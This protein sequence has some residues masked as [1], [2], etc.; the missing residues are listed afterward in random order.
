MKSILTVLFFLVK[1]ACFAQDSTVELSPGMF[2][3]SQLIRLA[4][5]QGWIYKPGND[6]S[7]ANPG[8]NTGDWEKLSPAQLTKKM[9]AKDGR[10]EG[11]FRIKIKPD[12]SFAGMGNGLGLLHGSWSA[13]EVYIDGK[14]FHAFGNPGNDR[15]TFKAY[16]DN[17]KM[18]VPVNLEAGKDH[19]LA[20]HFAD[21]VDPVLRDLR[22]AGNLTAFLSLAAPGYTQQQY[23]DAIINRQIFATLLAMV[24]VLT[25][26]FW[27]IYFQNRKEK[28]LLWIAITA[29]FQFGLSLSI[30]L[31]NAENL[32]YGQ[33]LVNQFIGMISVQGFFVMIPITIR[34]IFRKPVPK[35]YWLVAGLLFPVSILF[36]VLGT[37][38]ILVASIIFVSF[39][40]CAVTIIS[41]WKSLSGARWAIVTGL[42]ASVSIFLLIIISN[43]L[44]FDIRGPLL[45]S[46][47]FISFPLGLLVYVSIWFKESR[48]AVEANAQK[49]IRVTEEKKDLL[50]NQNRLLEQQ[51]D[52]RTAE[53]KRSLENL[54]A[55]QSQL[56]QSEKM[57][58]LGELTAGIAH[59][60][61]N[62]L[63]FVNNFSEVSN[64]L[65][66]EMNVEIEKGDIAEAKTIGNDIKQ[67]LEKILH[68][69][70]RADAIVKGMLQHS[71]SSSGQKE[72]TDINALCDEYLRL[73][74]HGLRAKDKNFNA[75]LETDFDASLAKVNVVPQDI[76]R[77]V[78]NLITNAFYA[79]HEKE[80]QNIAGYEPTVTVSTRNENGKVIIS[81]KD[82]GNGIPDSIKDKIF[83]P[84]FTTK[85]TGQGTGLGLSLSYDIIKA[86]SG[87]IKLISKEEKGTEFIIQLPA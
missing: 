84:F 45:F 72:P 14:L 31:S 50:A 73:A 30:L 41:S 83:Q 86:H 57:A 34:K 26:L 23:S 64:E 7:W 82:N 12:S 38:K 65:I 28:H 24:S 9:A 66:D 78:L 21:Y 29:T 48:V 46:L 10:L 60:I 54:K 27:L 1:L 81:V 44:G 55:T 16:N 33:S 70:K 69:G 4:D 53:L 6:T 47:L 62:P 19:L 77:V 11:W 52:E 20:I 3:K 80:K 15:H 87:E 67:N 59:E 13:A 40:V 5:S 51:V 36:R 68:H 43:M 37:T 18:P 35:L 71:R 22:S 17:D 25:L 74:Y 42:I 49:I 63:N 75:N 39:I 58:S 56:I 32:S 2:D 79:V 76:G 85:P 61:Q 8:I